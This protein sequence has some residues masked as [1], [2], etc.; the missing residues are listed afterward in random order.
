MRLYDALFR[1]TRTKGNDIIFEEKYLSFSLEEYYALVNDFFQYRWNVVYRREI[2]RFGLPLH[3]NHKVF[4]LPFVFPCPNHYSP[5]LEHETALIPR[6]LYQKW[7]DPTDREAKEEYY[8]RWYDNGL[9]EASPGDQRDLSDILAEHQIFEAVL[10]SGQGFQID[11][12][13]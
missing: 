6:S 4:Y 9:F 10:E 12:K 8:S 5:F 2:P 13:N 11:N 1:R 3:A 7:F